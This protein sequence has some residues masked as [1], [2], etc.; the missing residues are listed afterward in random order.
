MSRWSTP[1]FSLAF[2]FGLLLSVGCSSQKLREE[3][4][5]DDG[6]FIPL[7]SPSDLGTV[8]NL[9]V[10]SKA[11]VTASWLNLRQAAGTD[12][13]VV[14]AMPCGAQV[15]VVSGPSS[16]PAGWWNVTYE[17]NTGWASGKYLVAESDFAASLCPAVTP[18]ATVDGGAIISDDAVTAIF[19]RAKLA[20]GYSYYWG[21]GS[22]A[23]DGS[24]RGSCSGYCPDCQH[25]GQYGADCSG[26]VA[27]VWQVPNAS[28]LDKDTHPYSTYNFYNETNREWHQVPRS[29]LKAGDA[30]V[31][32]KD[33]SGHIVLVEDA[34]DPF[35]DLWLYEARACMIG[36]VHNLRSVD[37][38][39]IAIRRNDLP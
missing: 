8:G 3:G 9:A 29:E 34:S 18:I 6:G 19:D 25:T 35:G 12:A 2:S 37:S 39:F 5:P 21:H 32:R 10:G 23:S 13:A 7:D 38:S 36:I 4:D 22:W 17:Q 30:L 1:V 27:K 28:A 20:V 16:T 14:V 33:T 11:R 24:N 15:N 31:R 26:F